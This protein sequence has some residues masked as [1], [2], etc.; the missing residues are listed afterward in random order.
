MRDNKE[1]INDIYEECHYC[2]KE[3]ENY[4]HIY[5]NTED[6]NYCCKKCT[7]KYKFKIVKFVDAVEY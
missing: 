2:G 5:V 4:Q 7:K 3:F 6:D 1:I